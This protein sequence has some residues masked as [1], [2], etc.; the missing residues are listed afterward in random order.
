MKV[1]EEYQKHIKDLEQ[2]IEYDATA[3]RMLE[4]HA[5][6]RDYDNSQLA[7]I[8]GLEFISAQIAELY[9]RGN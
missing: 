5:K 1:L 4:F 7:I 2:G 8:E 3:W 6:P 9:N